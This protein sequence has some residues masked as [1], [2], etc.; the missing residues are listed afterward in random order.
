MDFDLNDEQRLLADNVARMMKDR[1]GF[2]SRKAYRATPLGFSEELWRQYAEL[3]L[4]GV[5][6]AEAD[7]GFG[8]GPVETM[9]IME[10]FGRALVLEPYL[11]TVVLAGGLV[12]RGASAAQR[13]ALIPQI[14]AGDLRLAFAHSEPQSGWDLF[15]VATS[16][17][18]DGAGYV[19]TGEKGLVLHG[20]SGQKLIVS[21]RCAGARRDRG[22]VGL[23]LVDAA[24]PGVARRGYAT[25][26]GLRAAEVTLSG[27]RVEADDVIG[28]PEGG[29]PTIA[30]VVDEAIAALCAEA[31]GAMGE[32]LEITVDYLKT[33]KQFGVAIGS[34]QAL[35][36]RAADMVVAVEQARSM[37]MLATITAGDDDDAARGRA[38]SAAKAQIGRSTR[39]VGQQATQLHGGIAMTFEYKLGHLF[40]RMTMIDMAFGDVDAH[41]R[42]LG[43]MD[44]L[45]E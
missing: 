16:A 24:A 27:V 15:D 14:V 34:F 10:A 29:A 5:P 12:R 43:E 1:Y 25:Q 41:L 9:L 21:A 45:F 38:I 20:D 30:R 23:F 3:G 22:G 42:R 8:G 19:L 18:K 26:D 17:R 32:A 13:A 4:L 36:H 33:R 6:F 7:G 11:A 37:M 40:K 2:E 44:S 35:Q 31:V 28:D 39:F